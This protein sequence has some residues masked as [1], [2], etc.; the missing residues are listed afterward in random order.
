MTTLFFAF[1]GGEL[2]GDII[3]PA[4]VILFLV[5]ALVVSGRDWK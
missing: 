2:H 4:L 5:W 3:I 1:H